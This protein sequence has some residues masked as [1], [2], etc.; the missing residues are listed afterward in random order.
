LLPFFIQPSVN[1]EDDAVISGLQTEVQNL[2][3]GLPA[4]QA[5][6]I[7]ADEDLQDQ[8]DNLQTPASSEG[9]AIYDADNNFIGKYLGP[10]DSGAFLG[11]EIDGEI[12]GAEA[13]KSGIIPN[14]GYLYYKTFS[15]ESWGGY[16]YCNVP[17]CLGEPYIPTG[18]LSYV[19]DGYV[20]V[21]NYPPPNNKVTLGGLLSDG[22]VA[23]QSLYIPD[24]DQ[25]EETDVYFEAYAT[26]GG[27]CRVARQGLDPFRIKAATAKPAKVGY[28]FSIHNPNWKIQ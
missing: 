20:Y 9:L 14:Q 15:C 23:G 3:G 7:A 21:I 10:S 1:A 13:N 19:P 26:P 8:I 28:D 4:E 17:T 16:N 12:Y 5:A 25:P 2:K 22:I 24:P 18:N 11:I 6:R 27:F